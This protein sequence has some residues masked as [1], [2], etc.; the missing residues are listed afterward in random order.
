MLSSF[1]VVSFRS[2]LLI[3][4]SKT[5]ALLLLDSS[6]FLCLFK[7]SQWKL[8]LDRAGH[9]EWI[10]AQALQMCF[11]GS[12]GQGKD[13]KR[14]SW[15]GSQD[16]KRK[17]KYLIKIRI[18]RFYFLLFKGNNPWDG[19]YQLVP[20][21]ILWSYF[22]DREMGL[23]ESSVISG[24]HPHTALKWVLNYV[25]QTSR[26]GLWLRPQLAPA[27]VQGGL[28]A[29]AGISPVLR[30]GELLPWHRV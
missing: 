28:L 5:A 20:G 25:A 13:P 23:G 10:R 4:L 17:R 9:M 2:V 14:N 6:L 8:G 11:W 7:R 30:F 22:M 15:K 18:S 29:M 3:S 26:A 16:E 1:E 12:V 24:C 19:V 27:V 21:R